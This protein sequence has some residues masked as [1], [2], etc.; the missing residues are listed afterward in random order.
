MSEPA[1]WLPADYVHP[2]TVELTTG[3]HI[4]PIRES[5]VAI[6][7]PA[8]MG[9]Q[10]RLFSIFGPPWGWPTTAISYEDDQEELARHEREIRDHV[11]FNY[12][13]LDAAESALLGCIYIDPAER[14]GADADISW[15]VV[16]E[17][18]GGALDTALEDFVPEW[19][20]TAW[21][22]AKPRFIPRDLTWAQWLALPESD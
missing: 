3:H 14:V 20:A 10:E 15:W 22:F 6:D 21:P 2:D 7:Y 16:D 18:V 11:S 19:I 1:E 9:S 17:E 12:A 8:V 13:I 5:D 4:R